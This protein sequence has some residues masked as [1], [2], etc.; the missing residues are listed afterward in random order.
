MLE[1]GTVISKRYQIIEKLGSGGMA[2]AY[3]ARDMR[4]GRFVTVK[5]LKDEYAENSEFLTKFSS[6]ASAA[7][8]LSHHNIVRVYDV[9]EDRGINYI[10]MEYVHGESLKKT[11]EQKAPFDSLFS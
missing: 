1:K 10:V 6:E 11:I 3:K 9:G 7:A 4:L 5:V 2:V 8:S